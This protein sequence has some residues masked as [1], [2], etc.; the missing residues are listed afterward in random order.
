MGKNKTNITNLPSPDFALN[1]LRVF[2]MILMIQHILTD[3]YQRNR[4]IMLN[5]LLL[6]SSKHISKTDLLR[7]VYL[8]PFVLSVSHFTSMC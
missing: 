2:S 1:I 6:F 3:K 4:Y 5:F 7:N 8:T